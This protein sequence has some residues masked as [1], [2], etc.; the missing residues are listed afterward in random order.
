MLKNLKVK[1]KIY[2]IAAIFLL[3]IVALGAFSISQIGVAQSAFTDYSKFAVAIERQTL[4]ITSDT[5]YVSRLNRSIILGGRYDKD[6]AALRTRVNTIYSHYDELERIGKSWPDEQVSEKLQALIASAFA[7]TKVTLDKSVEIM[8]TLSESSSN[9][10]RQAAWE[11]YG[12]EV[13][14]PAQASRRSF[15]ELSAYTSEQGAEIYSASTDVAEQSRASTVIIIAALLAILIGSMA[16]FFIARS[17]TNPLKKLSYIAK[18]VEENAQLYLRSE[19]NSN[20]EL[21]TVSR[22]VDDLLASFESTIVNIKSAANEQ[23][24]LS[25]YLAENSSNTTKGVTNQQ[26]DTEMVATAMT[27]MAS[28]AQEIAHSA[29]ETASAAQR[30]NQQSKS[31]QQTVEKTIGNISI[32]AQE[33]RQNAKIIEKVSTDSEEIGRILDVIGGIAEQTNLLALN[34]AI[35][36]ARAGEQGRGFAVVADEVRTLASRTNESTQEIKAMIDSLQNG[37]KDAVQAMTRSQEQADQTVITAKDADAAL[38]DITLAV[39]QINDMAAQIATAAEQQTSVNEE[40][41]QNINNIT[42]A[43]QDT[44]IEASNTQKASEDL[45]ELAQNLRQQVAQFK[46]Q[47]DA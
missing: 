1:T 5:N 41:S 2:G 40:I 17:I 46:C 6:M 33:I 31:G 44:A 38:T 21:G 37:S 24:R 22:A 47:D 19:L 34:A 16:S 10:E 13:T 29:A 18:E 25:D 20:D 8:G 12:D 23:M 42:L 30:A 9:F 27:E 4:I 15:K 32:L 14:P 7:L 11:R 36:A 28:T 26:H 3:A 45:S 43:S 35:E 39:G